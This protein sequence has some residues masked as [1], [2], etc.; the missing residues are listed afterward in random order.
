MQ[1]FAV[2]SLALAAVAT[3][4]STDTTPS[5]SNDLTKYLTQTNSLGVITGIPTQP[6]VD[7]V[8]PTQ[9]AVVTSQPLVASIY[10]GLT[11]GLN[12]VIVGNQT[13]TVSIGSGI[14]SVIKATP[15]PT[16]AA[17]TAGGAAASGSSSASASKASSSGSSAAGHIKAGAGALGFAG[18]IFALL[19]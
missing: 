11:T 16:S 14:T 4:Q 1:S 6:A 17:G 7:T 2:L 12:T 5:Y 9:P 13:Q 10:A 19:L 15:T 8:I 18:A 3:A